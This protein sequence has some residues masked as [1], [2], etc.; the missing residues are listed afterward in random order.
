MFRTCAA[1]MGCLLAVTVLTS[2]PPA[3]ASRPARAL[4]AVSGVE[5]PERVLPARKPPMGM[6]K[7]IRRD[8]GLTE[9]QAQSRLLNESRLTSIAAQLRERLGDRFAGSWLRGVAGQTLVVATTGR[10]DAAQITAAGARPLIVARSLTRL[11]AVKEK[12]A[13]ARPALSEVSSVR[14]IDVRAN[15]VVISSSTPR[16]ATSSIKAAGVSPAAVRVVLSAEQPRLLQ[17]G[18]PVD[19]QP[20][21]PGAPPTD[22]V[23]GQAYYSG[24]TTRCSVGFAV[25]RGT[26]KGFIS[27]GHCGTPGTATVGFNRLTQGSVRASTFPGGDHSW[28]ALDD[29]WTPRPLVGNDSGGIMYVYGAKEAIEGSSVCLAGSSAGGLD[30]HCGTITQREADVTYPEGVVTHMMRTSACAHPG[31]AGASMLSIGQAQGIVSGGSGDCAT[32]GF[33]YVQPLGDILTA[34]GL[35][36][37]TYVKVQASTGSCSGYPN[38]ATG[39][40]SSGQSIYQPNGLHYRTTVTGSHFGCVEADSNGDFDLH[41]Q[42]LDGLTWSTVAVSETPRPFEELG[43]VGP[44]GVYRYLLLSFKGSGSYTLGYTTP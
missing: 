33:T 28:V 25:T 6:L 24:A 30:W 14:Y 43:Y 20:Y 1:A 36:L 16:A 35:T 7:A 23:G 9:D 15:K 44:P 13:T 26:Q 32:G 37:M 34:Y 11:R 31:N 19:P 17:A 42:K 12:L 5:V 4:P 10:A 22:L 27:A 41:L 3:T 38:S 40:L 2:T 8:L 18:M 21:P 39:A 29:T